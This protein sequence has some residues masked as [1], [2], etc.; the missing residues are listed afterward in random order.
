[1]VANKS[2]K[3]Q[4]QKDTRAHL[5]ELNSSPTLPA[6]SSCESR[7]KS[8]KVVRS[9]RIHFS[10]LFFVVR[11]CPISSIELI[12]LQT[13]YLFTCTLPLNVDFTASWCLSFLFALFFKCSQTFKLIS[14]SKGFPESF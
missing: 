2:D 7:A 12:Q 10:L 13:G 3:W 9:L 11:H 5:I 4:A 6:T 14:S 8:K 1:M